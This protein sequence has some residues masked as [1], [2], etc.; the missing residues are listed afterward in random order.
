[1]KTTLITITRKTLVCL[2]LAFFCMLFAKHADAKPGDGYSADKAAAYADSCFKKSGGK[3]VAKP[4]KKYGTELCAGFVSQCLKEGGMTM[5]SNWYWK[6]KSKKSRTWYNCSALYSYLR[7]CKYKINYSPTDDDVQKG[8][9]IFYYTGGRWGHVS[10]CVGKKADGTPIVDAYNNAKY[11]HSN[12]T[13][14]YKTCVVSMESRTNT[15]EIEQSCTEKG[16]LVTISCSTPDAAIYYTTDGKTPNINSTKYTKP[17][18]VTKNCV[19]RAI[20]NSSASKTS[21]IAKYTIDI[22]KTMENGVYYLQNTANT[23]LALGIKASS[24]CLMQKKSENYDRKFQVTY[25]GNGHYNVTSLNTKLKI[26]ENPVKQQQSEADEKKPAPEKNKPTGNQNSNTQVSETVVEEKA[27]VMAATDT[28]SGTLYQT[29]LTRDSELW[30]IDIAGNNRYYI[31]N[32]KT[33][34][35]LTTKSNPV[36][37]STVYMADNKNGNN[38]MWKLTSATIS[39]FTVKLYQTPKKEKNVKYLT[40][41]GIISSNYKIE[42][43]NIAIQ[44]LP[45]KKTVRRKN[46]KPGKKKVSLY[47]MSHSLSCKGLKAGKYKLIVTACDASG[48]TKTV[49]NK[50]FKIIK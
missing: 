33:S 12:W 32:N 38:T 25:K 3:Y 49:V 8:D 14:N 34:H 40:L 28:V 2:S 35:Y 41:S 10:I 13:M 30:N 6:S 48:Q 50:Q 24:F 15:P 45:S 11:H 4:N 31:T 21:K 29:S 39:K 36:L 18:T 17:F 20:A 7:N 37:G 46:F 16:T 44:S 22:G 47:E 5:D 9:V 19:V 42:T 27:A 23:K 1:M 43:A 26:S